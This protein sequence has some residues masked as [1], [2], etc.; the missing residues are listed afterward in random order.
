MGLFWVIKDSA[1]LRDSERRMFSAESCLFSAESCL[2]E[3]W[4]ELSLRLSWVI[5]ELSWSFYLIS[6]FLTSSDSFCFLFYRTVIINDISCSNFIN[7]PLNV[8]K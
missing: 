6:L 7:D 1:F 8:Y 2:L 4:V 3:S 5:V